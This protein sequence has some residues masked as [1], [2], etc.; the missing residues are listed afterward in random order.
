[1]NE[2]NELIEKVASEAEAAGLDASAEDLAELVL[3]KIAQEDPDDDDVDDAIK[4]AVD[5]ASEVL[6]DEEPEKI[7]EVAYEA[8]E[9]AAK[10]TEEERNAYISTVALPTA[11]AAVVPGLGLG[12][13]LGIHGVGRLSKELAKKRQ[14]AGKEVVDPKSFALRH[15]FISHGLAGGAGRVAAGVPAYLLA[16]RMGGSGQMLTGHIL[17]T[18]GSAAGHA[19][20]TREMLKG[21][22]AEMGAGKRKKSEL[23]K[24]AAFEN[25]V[26]DRSRQILVQSGF[27]PNTGERM[28]KVALARTPEEVKEAAALELLERRGW[29]VNWSPEYL[30][31]FQQEGVDR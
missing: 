21:Q 12:L 2:I 23:L 13:G 24:S 8:L 28:S 5:L 10:M 25:G 1:M 14:E 9:K 3:D 4:T 6:P 11:G 30:A 29:P 18:A 19:L 26:I 17:G 20:A 22:K 7:A 27:D 15:P 31:R 16:R